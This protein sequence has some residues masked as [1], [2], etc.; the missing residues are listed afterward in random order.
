MKHKIKPSNISNEK[1]SSDVPAEVNNQHLLDELQKRQFQLEMR[2]QLLVQARSEAEAALNQ[3]TDLYDFAPV[4]YLTLARDGTIR[5]AN[6]AAA[7]LLG[8]E[9]H[10]LAQRRLGAFVSIESNSTYTDFLEKLISGTGKDTC[11]LALGKK[12]KGSLWARLEATCFEGG[13]EC[14]VLLTDITERKQAASLLQAR[15]RLSEFSDS[16]SLDEFLQESLD[17]AESLTGS[18]IG[19]AH[20]LEADQKTLKLQ[21]WSSNTLKNMCTAEGKGSHYAVDQA[22]VWADCVSVR[23]PLIHNNYPNLPLRKGLPEGHAPVLRELVVPI[24]RNDLI[25]MIM[26]VGNKPTDYDEKDV[27]ALSQLANSTWDIVQRKRVEKELQESEEHVRVIFETLSEGIALNEIVFN[28]DGEMVDYKVLEVNDAFYRVADFDKDKIIIGNT[29]TDLYGMDEQTIKYFWENHKNTTE[30]IISEFLS[31]KSKRTFIVSTSPFINNRFVTS[32]QDITDRKRA[33]ME[34]QVFSEITEGLV[35][36]GDLHE[37]LWLVHNSISKLVYA[38]NFFVILHDKNTDLFEEVYSVDK[39]DPP[40]PPARLRRSTSAYVFRSGQPFLSTPARFDELIMQ[41]EVELVGTNSPSWLGVPLKTAG[42]ILGVMVIQD[43]ETPDRYSKYDMDLL[44]S[45]ATQVALVLERKQT[46]Q[47]I[48]QNASELELRVEERTLD[49][50]RANRAKDEFLANMSHELRTPLNSIMGF[51]ELYLEGVYGPFNEKQGQTIQTVQSSGQ[52]L[53]GLINDILD[54]SKIEAGKLELHPEEIGVHEICQSSLIYIK[55]M[56]DKKSI[57]VEYSS[58]PA[59]AEVF[60]D[61]K[62]LKQ[63]LVNLLNNAVK[64]T[65]KNGTVKLEAAADPGLSLMRFSVTDTG[66]G[67]TPE[68]QQKLFKP[69]VQIDSSLSRQYEGTG[70]GLAL[71]K[72]MVEMHGGSVAVQSDAGVGSQFTFVLPWNQTMEIKADPGLP[73]MVSEKHDPKQKALPAGCGKILIA[74]DN[75]VNVIMLMD[76]LENRGHQVF[77]AHHGGEVLQEAQRVS[78]DVILMDLQMPQVNGFEA[79]GRLRKDPQFASVTI[80]GLTAFAMDGDRERCLEA[81]MD[82]YV[83]KPFSLKDLNQMIENF[84]NHSPI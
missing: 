10:E 32:F 8:M 34:R 25:V 9:H 29:A 44:T 12:E 53:L 21:M 42:E 70:L 49:L 80:I 7:N 19:F 66:I 78:P 30:T 23:A 24:L 84:I 20:F 61:P 46:E 47:L 52:H 65:P 11:E 50:I 28:S 27:V 16:H 75:E 73:D 48:R 36:T 72:K 79:T 68:D 69:F 57:T 51:S 31:P 41:G 4:G 18:Q 6:L 63:I 64:F 15:I 54:I 74:D 43:Y 1:K 13:H 5:Q 37:F 3:Y 26:G 76:Y 71:V 82:E 67:I 83:S 38:E 35:A 39:F 17:Q 2:N 22:G 58:S 81:G 45:I 60:A 56:A 33:E 14:R 62:L 77:V 59:T 55:P 40:G